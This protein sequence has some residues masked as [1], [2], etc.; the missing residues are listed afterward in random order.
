MTEKPISKSCDRSKILLKKPHP[1][2][3]FICSHYSTRSYWQIIWNHLSNQEEAH[4][5]RKFIG[6]KNRATL[7]IMLPNRYWNC[8]HRSQFTIPRRFDVIIKA[9][10][11]G[12]RTAWEI[13]EIDYWNRLFLTCKP[14]SYCAKIE[15]ILYLYEFE[16]E[17]A[18]FQRHLFWDKKLVWR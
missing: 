3:K 10:N 5:E 16:E 4:K 17:E 11:T 8:G 14:K 9:S 12:L 13:L 2:K 1:Y 7:Q 6:D 18:K 15:I